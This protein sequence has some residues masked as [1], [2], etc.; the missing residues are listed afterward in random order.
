MSKL[1][2]ANRSDLEKELNYLGLMDKA[3]EIYMELGDQAVLSYVK[4]SHRLLSKVYHPDLN[5]EKM[6]KAKSIQQRLNHVSQIIGR[7]TDEELIDL[8]KTGGL[9]PANGKKKILIVEDEDELQTLFRNVMAMEGY[10]IRVASDGRS[11]YAA[12]LEYKPDLVLT[13]VVMPDIGGLEL[14][15]KIREK[16]FQVK[17]IY[18]SG[19]F[20]L[21]GVKRDL[22]LEINEFGYPTLA[23]PFKI[24]AL[25]TA[26]EEYLN[27]SPSSQFQ[28]GV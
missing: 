13:D 25:L 20:G 18:M 15:R 21:E 8:V 16:D 12:Y 3:R 2:V 23:K 19:F 24:S 9:N 10:D 5:P 7:M 17:V 22:E 28:R 4:S 6:E 11:G 1:T 27:R 14:V 26:V